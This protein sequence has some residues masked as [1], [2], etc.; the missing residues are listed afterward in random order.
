MLRAAEASN[1]THFYLAV[2]TNI[3]SFDFSVRNNSGLKSISRVSVFEK[4]RDIE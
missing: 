1:L 3:R 4:L 2:F